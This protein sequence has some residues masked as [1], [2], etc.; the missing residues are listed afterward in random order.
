[1]TAFS[2]PL[3]PQQQTYAIVFSFRNYNTFQ[4]LYRIH[5]G[6]ILCA[7]PAT[8]DV[9]MHKMIPVHVVA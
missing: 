3:C 8:L 1:M 7:R 5:A 4:L 6:I 2:N 9:R